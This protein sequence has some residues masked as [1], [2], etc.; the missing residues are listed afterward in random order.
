MDSNNKDKLDFL[1]ILE[2]GSRALLEQTGDSHVT[3]IQF[4]KS[5]AQR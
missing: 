3:L 2:M 4:L 5:I 1:D